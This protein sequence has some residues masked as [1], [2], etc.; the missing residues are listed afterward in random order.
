MYL[1][2]EIVLRLSS[3]Q[4]I[5]VTNSTVVADAVAA[6]AEAEAVNEFTFHVSLLIY[7]AIA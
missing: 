5:N 1:E 6:A 4:L 2:L 3:K 7:L